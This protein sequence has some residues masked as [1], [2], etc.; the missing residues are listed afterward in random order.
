M[1]YQQ[2]H[3]PTLAGLAILDTGPEIGAAGVAR[4]R[5]DAE[6]MPD[7][8]QTPEDYLA[9]LRRSYIMAEPAALAAWAYLN[10]RRLPT[11]EWQ[12]KTDPAFTRSL[13]K[14]GQH[15]GDAS[16]LAAPLDDALIAALRSVDC[17][18]LLLRGQLSAILRRHSAERM[19]NEWLRKARLETIA[20][21]GHAL[22][23]DQP[24]AVAEALAE[25]LAD[26]GPRRR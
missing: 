25:F 17:P 26:L 5:R 20:N 22:A 2:R 7:R 3:R 24:L 6:A 13:W 16:D 12:P 11:G 4:V 23:V 14:A 18:T 10:L 15:N 9:W 1:L 19:V 8:F 21:A